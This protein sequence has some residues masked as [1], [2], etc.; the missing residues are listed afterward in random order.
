MRVAR[1]TALAAL[2]LVLSLC[3][4]SRAAPLER[5]LEA[6]EVL[7]RYEQ[8]IAAASR[9][10]AVEFEYTVEQLG[11]HTLQQEHHVYRSGQGER[12]EIVAVDGQTLA[13]PSVR[14][15]LNHKYPYDI[16]SVAPT[17]AGYAFAYTG[18]LL[19]GADHFF[20]LFRTEPKGAEGNFVVDEVEI[21]G[22]TFLP[23]EIHFR[24]A[25]DTTHGSG[26]LAYARF[27]RYW[28]VREASVSVHLPKGD[29][30]NE[31]IVWSK[32][33]FPDSLPAETFKEPAPATAE[34]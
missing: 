22:A 17:A 30:A 24:I 4:A 20:Y 21:D 1:R 3:G 6:G 32:Y 10:N 29:I 2:A 13:R 11:A 14:I 26:R 23:S 31:R 8:A 15:L 25:T 27:D 33:Q 9:P 16:R 34:E 19:E 12:D 28:L 18:T 7:L 5:P